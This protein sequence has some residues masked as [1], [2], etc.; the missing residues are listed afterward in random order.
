MDDPTVRALLR[1][2]AEL[3]GL[4]GVQPAD[5]ELQLVSA[6]PLPIRAH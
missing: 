6:E 4:P 3:V 1:R 5:F 2:A